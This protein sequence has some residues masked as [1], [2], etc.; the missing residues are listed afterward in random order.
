MDNTN[1]AQEQE[2]GDQKAE[3][4]TIHFYW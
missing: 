4:K 2:D 1:D 3:L